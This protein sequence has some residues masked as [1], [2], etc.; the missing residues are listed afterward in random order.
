MFFGGEIVPSSLLFRFSIKTIYSFADSTLV[1]CRSKTHFL[2]RRFI[3]YSLPLYNICY[4][5]SVKSF[6]MKRAWNVIIR[7]CTLII[8]ACCCWEMLGWWSSVIL[9]RHLKDVYSKHATFGGYTVSIGFNE[10]GRRGTSL[11][12]L[13]NTSFFSLKSS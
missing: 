6:R 10:W 8:Y 5:M 13:D 11:F 12:W 7:E 9:E 1:L 3:I 4:K 2:I